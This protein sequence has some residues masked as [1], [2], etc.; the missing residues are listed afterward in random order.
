MKLLLLIGLLVSSTSFSAEKCPVTHQSKI[1]EDI[2]KPWETE[3]WS[4]YSGTYI[5]LEV[6]GTA[7]ERI[8]LT[9]FAGVGDAKLISACMIIIADLFVEPSYRIHGSITPD[10]ETGELDGFSIDAWRMVRYNDPVT[11]DLVYGIS[12]DGRIY[13]DRSKTEPAEQASTG[14]PATRSESKSEGSDKPQ[15]EA[16]GLSR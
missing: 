10:E 3:H 16:E 13:V 5:A 7:S 1:S 6:D 8:I 2:V 9:A 4:R 15:P 12:V 11:N 14:Q